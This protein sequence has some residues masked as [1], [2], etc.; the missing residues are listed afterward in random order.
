MVTALND[1][2]LKPE[3]S[4]N[5]S[6]FFDSLTHRSVATGHWALTEK[7]RDTNEVLRGWMNSQ[8]FGSNAFAVNSTLGHHLR[9]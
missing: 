8:V 9:I 7:P 6:K 2:V 5:M 1:A 3:M 4:Q